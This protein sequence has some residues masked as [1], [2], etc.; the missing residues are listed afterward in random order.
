MGG[1]VPESYYL[2]G[3]DLSS[4]DLVV[5]NVGRGSTLQIDLPVQKEHSAIR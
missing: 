2:Q 1:N 3:T 5:A 4:E